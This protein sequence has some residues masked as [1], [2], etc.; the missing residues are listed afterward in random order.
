MRCS[1]A[2][3]LLLGLCLALFGGRAS[4]CQDDAGT[5]SETATDELGLRRDLPAPAGAPR[6]GTDLEVMTQEVSEQLRC[7]MCQGMSVADSPS[8][9]ARAIKD[10]VRSLLAEGFSEDQVKQYFEGTYGEFVLLS[11]KRKGLNWLLW[12][13]PGVVF[14]GGL[15]W[16]AVSR[17]SKRPTESS[18]DEEELDPY[19]ERVRDLA[20]VG[21]SAEQRDS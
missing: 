19:L 15:T 10:E 7:P 13:A 16:I 3:V 5:G 12:L 9:S 11:P 4:W 21:D 18:G 8:A 1:S 20:R 6:S 14:L 17:S 2:A